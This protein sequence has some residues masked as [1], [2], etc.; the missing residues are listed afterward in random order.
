[1]K[2]KII[3][4]LIMFISIITLY[5]VKSEATF[6]I[7]N[8]QIN[9][10]VQENGNIDI[11]E[12]ITYCTNENKNGL[13]RTIKTKNNVNPTNS[14]DDLILQDVLVD[15]ESYQKTSA[16]SVGDSGVYTFSKSG[17]TNEI[18]V[19]S[20]F[21][22]N[23]KVVTYKY[24]LTN[25]AVKY[26]DIA[27]L[28]WNFIGNEWDC[29]IDQLTIN[30]N[31]PVD[32]SKGTI[33]VYGHGSDNGTFTKNA[34]Y[35]TLK[36][37]NIADYQ[38][39]DARIL[40]PTSAI[41]D[42]MKIVNKNVLNKYKN[43]EEGMTKEQE[44]PSI[45]LG[46]S[47]KEIAFGISAIILVAGVVIYIKYDKEYKV[48]KYKYYRDIPYNLE[49]ELLQKIY[50]GKNTKNAFW[51]TFLNLIKKGVFRIEKTTN[52]VGKE[53]QNIIYVKEGENLKKYQEIA[54]NEIKRLMG[55]KKDSI[56]I[57]KL[58]AKM[59]KS[60]SG[61]YRKFV[62]AL[63]SEYE[64]LF[65]EVK[66]APTKIIGILVVCMVAL[67]GIIVIM[68]LI[69]VPES[70]IAMV[71]AMFL[72]ITA[73][74]YST[75]FATAGAHLPTF[76]F[77][78]CHCSVFQAA[79]IAMLVQ[80]KLG[81][82]YI[83]YILLF[84]LIQYVTRVKKRSKEERQIREQ[85]KGLRRYLKDYSLLS[86]KEEV[87]EI[88][89]WEDYFI[90]A[91]ALDLNKKVIDDW[92]KYGENYTDSNLETS[93]YCVGGYAYMAMSMRPAFNSHAHS[94]HTGSSG[95][96]S[97]SGSSGGFSGGSSSG[98]GGRRWRWRKFLLIKNVKEGPAPI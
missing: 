59:K 9:C 83:P 94:T 79:N 27:E 67:I 36:A 14:A 98:G 1:M 91:I 25:V 54:R 57:L 70:G 63:D 76:I 30:I 38:A 8:F 5:S 88:A 47:V 56:D 75:V 17:N 46:L 40:F 34:N 78:L 80:T 60:T 3:I 20:P 66:K 28:Y 21:N 50:Y 84:I 39:V 86:Q 45:I 2:N 26:N 89:L 82:M 71:I 18:K 35:I 53:T 15:G 16:A 29:P 7:S 42:S 41:S 87:A 24:K 49:P 85:I 69:T 68:S 81:F 52:Q 74:I 72:G 19:F 4:G 95:E 22:T 58:E 44:A 62:D 96:S 61:W 43:I 97:Y 51:I 93:I 37:R 65:G 55:T 32:A 90:L 64:G 73:L 12:N 10:S 23:Y 92:Y 31:L 13:I 48:E 11:E 33:Y 77:L 6:K